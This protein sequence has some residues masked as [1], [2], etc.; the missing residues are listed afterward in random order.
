MSH[1]TKDSVAQKPQNKMLSR[2]MLNSNCQLDFPQWKR[3]ILLK[4]EENG[5]ELRGFVSEWPRDGRGVLERGTHASPGASRQG[6]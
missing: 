4:P 3:R 2:R 1:V 6:Q 5:F